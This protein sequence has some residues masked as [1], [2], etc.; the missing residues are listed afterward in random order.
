MKK[1]RTAGLCLFL[2]VLLLCMAWVTPASAAG[3]PLQY[4]ATEYGYAMV[5]GCDK[6]A[7]GKIAVP[8][9]ATVDGKSYAVKFI[10]EKAFAGCTGVTEIVIPEGVTQIGSKAFENCTSLRTVDMPKSLNNCQY[11]A[12]LGCENVMV[13]C[14]SSNY[15]FFAVYGLS[16]NIQVNV[17]DKQRTPEETKSINAFGD[18]IKRILQIIFSWFGIE[19]YK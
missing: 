14:Y 7:S 6:S 19:L 13:N 10:G 1:T 2:S 5:T 8:A 18:F 12:F 4:Q 11:D 17:L 3:A 15:Q 9:K 16:Q